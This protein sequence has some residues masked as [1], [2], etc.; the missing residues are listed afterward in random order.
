MSSPIAYFRRA[1]SLLD[2]ENPKYLDWATLDYLHISSMTFL[3]PSCKRYF[4]IDAI[5]FSGLRFY[6]Y[7]V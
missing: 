6:D 1:T 5:L 7:D 4:D 2:H 3:D